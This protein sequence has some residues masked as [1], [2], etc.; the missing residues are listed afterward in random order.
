MTRHVIIGRSAVR[1]QLWLLQRL[2]GLG[3]YVCRKLCSLVRNSIQTIKLCAG[4][5]TV[6][7]RRSHQWCLF[8]AASANEGC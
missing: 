6:V 5:S 8:V 7:S 3:L 1:T 4:Y 2:L